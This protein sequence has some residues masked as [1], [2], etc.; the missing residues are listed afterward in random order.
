MGNARPEF[1]ARLIS[2]VLKGTRLYEDIDSI[3][4]RQVRYARNEINIYLKASLAAWSGIFFSW[5]ERRHLPRNF[6]L[7]DGGLIH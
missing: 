1:A 6:P 3:L 4:S 2:A 7:L 5:R